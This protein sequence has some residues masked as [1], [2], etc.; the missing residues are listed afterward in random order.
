[1][2]IISANEKE[3][4]GERERRMSQREEGRKEKDIETVVCKE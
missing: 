3:R 2:T 4:E 1:V